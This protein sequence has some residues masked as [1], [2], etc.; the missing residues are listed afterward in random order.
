MAYPKHMS[1]TEA[2]IITKL[3]RRALQQGWTISVYDGEEWALVKSTD[4]EAI[5][6]EIAA[7]DETTLR[8]REY[9]I[10]VGSVFLV[11]G[12]EDEVISDMSAND[13]MDF[14]TRGL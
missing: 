5:T 14:I 7:T 9:G 8:F 13:A 10:S 3:I 11:H 1:A 2:R 4:F 6:A 12:N